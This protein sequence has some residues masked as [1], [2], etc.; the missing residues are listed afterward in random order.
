MVVIEKSIRNDKVQPINEEQVS[1]GGTFV[2]LQGRAEHIPKIFSTRKQNY[3]KKE[4]DTGLAS[5]Q[6]EDIM[7]GTDESNLIPKLTQ[8]RKFMISYKKQN[9]YLHELNENLMLSNKRMREDL[10]EKEVDY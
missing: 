4:M 8:I 9:E 7:V 3:D 10:E 5:I 1:E 2:E 6:K